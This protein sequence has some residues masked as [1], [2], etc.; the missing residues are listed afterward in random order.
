MGTPGANYAMSKQGL[1]SHVYINFIQNYNFA[2]HYGL[3]CNQLSFSTQWSCP[4]YAASLHTKE[5]WRRVHWCKRSV[6]RASF[7]RSGFWRVCET[8]KNTLQFLEDVNIHELKV[9]IDKIK[10]FIQYLS[11]TI[12]QIVSSPSLW[13]FHCM[14]K[15]R[16]VWNEII[17]RFSQRKSGAPGLGCSKPN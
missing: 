9:I 17:Y 5:P 12:N 13:V 1:N 2:Y 16:I 7:S 14:F 15:M 6:C 8:N 10:A 3:S 11:M 4:V